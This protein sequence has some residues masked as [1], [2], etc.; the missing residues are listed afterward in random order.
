MN[1]L[2]NYKLIIP[3]TEKCKQI[4]DSIIIE[5]RYEFGENKLVA[6][7]LLLNKYKNTFRLHFLFLLLA[8][9]I[10]HSSLAPQKF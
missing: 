4:L 7:Y 2:S 6:R 1:A 9:D 8:F 10:I 3:E 5:P